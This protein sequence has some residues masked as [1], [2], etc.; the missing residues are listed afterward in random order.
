LQMTTVL[1]ANVHNIALEGTFDDCQTIVKGL[2]NHHGFRDGARLSGVNSI[3]WGRIVAQIVYYFT[4]AVALGAPHRK[5]SF[6]VPTGNFGDIFAGFAAKQMGLPID[7]LIIATNENDILRRAIETGRY[8]KSGV[9]QTTSPSMDIEISSNF[10][11]LLFEALGRDAD[12]TG[13]LMSSLSQSGA[14]TIPDKALQ[15]MRQGFAAGRADETETAQT[16]AGVLEA[17]DYLIDPH[18]AVGIAVGRRNA[19][20]HAFHRS[21][22]K[23]PRR[24]KGRSGNRAGPADLAI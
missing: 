22:L 13:A 1:D 19:D 17:S 18:T 3:N 10:E 21:S 5:V 16:I 9:H 24:R 4:A 11:R 8:E 6:S 7:R 23:I 20:D 2:F 15:A 14:F 12:Q